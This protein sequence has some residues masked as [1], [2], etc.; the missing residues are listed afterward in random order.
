MSTAIQQNILFL[1]STANNMFA[2]DIG[3]KV[4]LR[5]L[6]NHFY[7]LYEGNFEGHYFY[8][9]HDGMRVQDYEQVVETFESFGWNVHTC[10]KD[11]HVY[12]DGYASVIEAMTLGAFA[13]QSA[14]DSLYDQSYE[15]YNF[16]FGI[17]HLSYATILNMLSDESLYPRVRINLLCNPV[18]CNPKLVEYA[19][20][21]VNTVN[22][23]DVRLERSAPTL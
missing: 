15:E 12:K 8:Q 17:T 3:G 7:N 1:D 23:P 10:L 9:Y 21:I 19:D 14:E 22:L 6:Y 16:T 2:E 4:D 18:K 5:K 13:I 11:T 20:N